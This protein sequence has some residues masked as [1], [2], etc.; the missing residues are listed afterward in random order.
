MSALRTK[1]LLNH[2]KQVYSDKGHPNFWMVMDPNDIATW[3]VLIHSLGPEHKG[4]EY[5]MRMTAPKNYPFG[6]PQF[7]LFTPNPRYTIGSS[8]PCVSMGE[9]HAGNYPALLGMYGFACEL[10]YSFQSSDAEM[11]GGISMKTGVTEKEKLK[12]A[13]ESVAFNNT[14]YEVVMKLFEEERKRK[15]KN[16]ISEIDTPKSTK[17]SKSSKSSKST[18]SSK[19]SESEESQESHESESSEE[20]P[21]K[22]SPKSNKTKEESEDSEKS[23]ESEE[24]PKKKSSKS[25]ESKKS[26]K[27]KEES[28]DSE[29]SEESEEKVK[30]TNISKKEKSKTAK[31]KK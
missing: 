17:S 14:H 25:R 27:T 24:K 13:A 26:N 19:T 30:K 3:Y 8:R 7:E 18:K 31:S 5:L 1:A 11:G 6:P 9:Y 21:K 22:K 28:E 4:G 2:Y 16:P 12:L 29:K 10:I 23:E 15:F 20:K